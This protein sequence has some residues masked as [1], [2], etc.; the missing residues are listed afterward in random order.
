MELKLLLRGMDQADPLFKEVRDR[1]FALP[2][3]PIN[4]GKL[5]RDVGRTR[6]KHLATNL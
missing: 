1:L 3:D 6:T 5:K 4:I 2:V